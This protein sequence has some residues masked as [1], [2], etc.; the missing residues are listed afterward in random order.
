MSFARQESGF[1][2]SQGSQVTKIDQKK[3]REMRKSINTVFM[4]LE[5]PS[6]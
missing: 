2:S 5:S 1:E 6:S 4:S 3:T